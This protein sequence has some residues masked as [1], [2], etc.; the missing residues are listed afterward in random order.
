MLFDKMA[1]AGRSLKASGMEQLQEE[2][3]SYLGYVPEIS[4][5]SGLES[6]MIRR[7]SD[8]LYFKYGYKLLKSELQEAWRQQQDQIPETLDLIRAARVSTRHMAAIKSFYGGEFYI[9]LRDIEG[10]QEDPFL[11]EQSNKYLRGCV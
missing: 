1:D 6:C 10:C 9:C 2:L 3:F 11:T 8:P 4:K 7:L 5:I